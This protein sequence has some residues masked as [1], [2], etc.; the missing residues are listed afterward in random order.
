M[1]IYDAHIKKQKKQNMRK[2]GQPDKGLHTHARTYTHAQVYYVLCK[3][4]R[5]SKLEN[6]VHNVNIISSANR[7]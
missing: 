4:D 6:I 7:K 2:K 1:G 5:D 3:I